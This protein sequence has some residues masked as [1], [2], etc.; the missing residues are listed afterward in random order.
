MIGLLRQ[1]NV[2]LLW[3]GG[4]IS[5]IGDWSLRIALPMFVYQATQSVF[6]TSLIAV[7]GM[8]PRLLLGSIAGV[9]VD[10][11]DRRRTMVIVN[12]LMGVWLLPLLAVTTSASVWLIA[13]VTCVQSV[14]GQFFRPAEHALLPQLVKTDQLVQANAL[15]SLNNSLARLIGPVIGG[16]LAGFV[17]LHGVVL[18]DA[19]S[20][21]LAAG[22]I[23]LIRAEPA[24]RVATGTISGTERWL[25][26]WREWLAGLQLIWSIRT[27]TILFAIVAITALGEGVFGVLIIAFINAILHGGAQE[28]GWL[29]GAQAV[30]GLVGGVIVSQF[31]NRLTPAQL[32]GF[33][34]ILFGLLDL[35]I[36]NYPAYLPG[37]EIGIALFI[38]VGIP[39]IGV[40]TGINTLLQS[41]VDDQYRGRVFG[42]LGTTEAFLALIGTLLAGGLGDW[43]GIV[44]VLNLQGL[45]YILAGV[46]ALVLIGSAARSAA[47]PALQRA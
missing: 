44:T 15:N 23:F 34:A 8:L 6:A 36:F 30:G 39:G 43:L 35:A 1:R 24:V 4:L 5:M 38:L 22:M 26:V 27:L 21:V 37:I 3:F 47:K 42:A 16:L 31:G 33:G 12:L 13:I 32:L 17:G 18:L 46:M 25:S 45:G 19:L 41:A 29:M 14:L 9:F 2:A 28:F 20:F 40:M 11:W 10:R 7:A